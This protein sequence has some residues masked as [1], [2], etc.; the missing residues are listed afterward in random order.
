MADRKIDAAREWDAATYDRISTPMQRWGA[1]V[2]ERLEL[3]GDERVL[4]AGCGT[5]RV[6]LEH[7]KRLPTGRVVALDASQ[8]MLDQARDVLAAYGDRVDYVLA[9]L[10]RPLPVEGQVDAILSTATFHWVPDHDALFHNLA[11]VL[12]PGGQ[13][14]AQC[15]GVGNVQSVTDAV[16]AVVG[17]GWRGPAHYESVE[18]TERRLAAAGFADIECWLQPEPTDF[19][20]GEPFETYLATVC[21]GAVLELLPDEERMPLVR[22]VAEAMPGPRLDYVRLNMT[23]RRASA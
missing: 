14:V 20:P 6:T 13:L 12:R 17:D 4:D 15:G 19:E 11:A 10:G 5:G 1:A 3:N 16:L 23:A 8:K 7:L 18:E 22:K 2:V 21:L 9:D